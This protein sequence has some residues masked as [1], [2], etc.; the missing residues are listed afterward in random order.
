MA[1]DR[2]IDGQLTRYP[3][4][5]FRKDFPNVLA[6]S[7]NPGPTYAAHGV[8]PRE[9]LPRPD[10]TE[11]QTVDRAEP[12]LTDGVSVHGWTVRDMTEGELAAD[13]A[14]R[15]AGVNAERDR[16]LAAGSTVTVS[17]Y[18][19]VPLQ[20]RAVDQTNLIALEVTAM[21]LV[22]AALD[23]PMDFRDADNVMHTLTPAQMLEMARLGKQA[24]A[25]IYAAAWALKDSG[26]IPADYTDDA[27]WVTP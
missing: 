3:I 21:Q 24:A 19:D 16:R 8:Y 9:V 20:G 11:A 5:N 7:K 23:V 13:Q 27:H 26:D 4:A 14:D 25:A 1:Y 18:G 10:V 15:A 17:G 2:L 12:V 6:P 22:A